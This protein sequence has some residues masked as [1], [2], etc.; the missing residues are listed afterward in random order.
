MLSRAL[1]E[2]RLV[3]Y[4]GG[5]TDTSANQNDRKLDVFDQ[6]FERLPIT[7]KLLLYLNDEKS[8]VCCKYLWY[9]QIYLHLRGQ[10]PVSYYLSLYHPNTNIPSSLPTRLL[11]FFSSS[12]MLIS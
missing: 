8:G 6:K 11:T 12:S 2:V 10:G 5:A 1:F 4:Y 7:C 9:I 3:Y